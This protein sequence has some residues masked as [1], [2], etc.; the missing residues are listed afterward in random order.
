M[1]ISEK[2]YY[3]LSG[4]LY[5]CADIPFRYSVSAQSKEKLL[6]ELEKQFI[7]ENFQ[8]FEGFLSETSHLYV[9]KQFFV[10]ETETP[11]RYSILLA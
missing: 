6:S 8:Y 2:T 1:K 10:S 4:F 3:I 9:D 11:F 5:T 7:E